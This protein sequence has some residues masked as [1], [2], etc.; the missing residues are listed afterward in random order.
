MSTN[1]NNTISIKDL[2]SIL[3][4]LFTEPEPAPEPVAEPEPAPVEE[5]AAPV[6]EVPRNIEREAEE[7]AAAVSA[8]GASVLALLRDAAKAQVEIAEAAGLNEADRRDAGLRR[9][10]QLDAFAAVVAG[11]VSALWAAAR[12]VLH[13]AA[14]FCAQN[15]LDCERREAQEDAEIDAL[16][17]KREIAR[18]KAEMEEEHATAE[19]ARDRK[20]L[21]RAAE[22]KKLKRELEG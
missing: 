16:H 19:Y 21:E 12:P 7:I 15:A 10:K 13:E 11:E 4:S 17:H 2:N 3:A 14:A 1:K 20:R 9:A 5:P 6:A 22:L 18:L 8:I